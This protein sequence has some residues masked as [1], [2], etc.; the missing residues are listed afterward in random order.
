[1][2]K[3]KNLIYFYT[4][5]RSFISNDIK[6]LEHNFD[7]HEYSFKDTSNIRLVIS[8]LQQ[9]FWCLFLLPKYDRVLVF[10][11]G[12]HSF[13]PSLF[14]KIYS[15]KCFIFLGGADCYAF[16]SFNYGHHQKWLVSKFNCASVRLAY[17]LVPVHESLMLSETSYYLAAESQ[18]GIQHFCKGLSTPYE[19]L[20]LEY[21]P[22]MFQ[23]GNTDKIQD[24]FLSVAFGIAGTSFYRKGIDLIVEIAKRLPN[25]TF[26]IIGVN[27]N[28]LHFQYPSNLSFIPPIQYESL[29]EI[30]S[31]H[32]F[33]LQLSI[34]E[35]FPSAICEAMLCNCTPIGSNVAAIPQIIGDSGYILQKK[36]VEHLLHLIDQARQN[37]EQSQEDP[38]SRIIEL[39]GPNTRK[40][41]LNSL[42]MK[43]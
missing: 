3:G 16:P 34:A 39:F 22:E 12:Y 21:D 36:N 26:N 15:K 18:Q 28:D 23:Q 31:K 33:Y 4:R 6:H 43:K 40:S 37:R 25:C 5:R 11:A 10:F 13:L 2:S 32:E 17:K 30:Y 9:F 35:G 27:H 1:M 8:F 19:T 24:S 7:I 38:R 42:I 20:Y 41:R 29:P 14:S